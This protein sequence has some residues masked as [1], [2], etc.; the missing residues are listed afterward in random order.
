MVSVAQSQSVHISAHAHTIGN[1]VY[2]H[3]H[4]Y[5]TGLHN[6]FHRTYV[7]RTHYSSSYYSHYNSFYTP[8][9]W[10]YYDTILRDISYRREIEFG[11]VYSII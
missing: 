7:P 4:C 11:M 8:N 10:N 2:V 1:S 5:T 9:D 6:H 3:S